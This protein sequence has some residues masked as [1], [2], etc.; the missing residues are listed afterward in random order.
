MTRSPRV[1]VHAGGCYYHL[2]GNNAP[3]MV[4]LLHSLAVHGV[5]VHAR[6]GDTCHLCAMT[7]MASKTP[8]IKNHG[9]EFA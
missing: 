5:A 3:P 4:P 2:T 6:A 8:S 9:V 7:K 1:L